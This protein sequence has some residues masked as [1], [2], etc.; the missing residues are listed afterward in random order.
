MIALVVSAAI[1]VYAMKYMDPSQFDGLLARIVEQ[2]AFLPKWIFFFVFGGFLAYNWETAKQWAYKWRVGLFVGVL[3]ILYFAAVEY[4]WGRYIGSNRV[5]NIINLP[6]LI[7]FIMAIAEKVGRNP[8]LHTVASK[9]GAMSMGI[10][11]IHPFVI[12]M[13]QRNMPEGVWRLSL[14]PLWYVVVMAITI[15]IILLVQKLPFGRV[16]LTVPSVKTVKPAAKSG[17]KDLKEA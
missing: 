11:L 9:L 10:Y 13:L 14:F 16:I 12:N 3:L 7:L 5:S 2:R 17:N 15:G 1:H 4:E 8:L 6:I